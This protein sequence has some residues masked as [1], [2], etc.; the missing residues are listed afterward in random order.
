[1][2]NLRPRLQACPLN[3]PF[4]LSSEI[5]PWSPIAWDDELGSPPLQPD[6][7][8][9]KKCVGLCRP[10]RLRQYFGEQELETAER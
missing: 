7:S 5:L 6:A 9:L 3:D 1:M 10:L 4:Q 8:K 2:K